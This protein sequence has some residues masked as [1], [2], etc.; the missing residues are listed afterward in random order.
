MSDHTARRVAF[1]GLGTMGGPMARNLLKAGHALSV[2]DVNPDAI[3]ALA[4][5]G[6]APATSARAAAE[7][8]EVAITMLPEPAD[9]ERAVLGEA[10][11]AAGLARGGTLIEMSTID[12]ATTRRVGKA[13]AA[14][15]IRMMDCPVGKTAE[16]AVAGTLTLMSGGDGALVEEMKPLLLAMGTDFFHCGALGA[17]QAMKLCNNLLAATI[18]SASAEILVA[19]VKSGL[20]LER[21][22]DVMRTTMAWNNQLAIA[23]PRKGFV[24]DFAPGF[25]LRLAQKDVRLAL[26][27]LRAV[28]VEPLLGEA[29]AAILAHAMK[30]G[31]GAED[32]GVVLRLRE[33]EAGVAVRLST[34]SAVAA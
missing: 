22:L 21:M 31:M 19:G 11:V 5:V 13:L 18:A 25:M 2:F 32:A 8:A 28:G 24:G 34:E 12:P 29:T 23:M 4:A 6:G 10:G 1:V 16:H 30:Q 14:K 20:R 33:E 15:G 3:A 9:V 7:R 27:L 17:G 26:G